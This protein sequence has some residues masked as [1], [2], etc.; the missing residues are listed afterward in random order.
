MSVLLPSGSVV[1]LE[2]SQQKYMIYG[3]L[4]KMQYNEHVYDYVACPYPQGHQTSDQNRIFDHDDIEMVYFIGL[5][6]A[7]E[8][9][10]R[11]NLSDEYDSFKSG[12]RPVPVFPSTPTGSSAQATQAP[13]PVAPPPSRSVASPPPQPIASPPPRPVAPSPPP[14]PAGNTAAPSPRGVF[15]ENC[16]NPVPPNAKF[17]KKCGAT[18]Y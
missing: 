18:Q 5:Q 11:E 17:C 2:G 14:R 15:C 16:A 10:Y 7:E 9:N 13:R 3:R 8:M 4:I 1:T 6:D 12:M